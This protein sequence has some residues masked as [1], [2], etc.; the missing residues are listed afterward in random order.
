MMSQKVRDA[1]N[2]QRQHEFYSS[3]RYRS[4]S[5]YCDRANLPASDPI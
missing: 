3:Y 5:A 1:F 4:M 2:E